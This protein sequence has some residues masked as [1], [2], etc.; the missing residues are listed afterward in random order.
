MCEFREVLLQI[1]AVQDVLRSKRIERIKGIPYNHVSK[2]LQSRIV[3][4]DVHAHLQHPLNM[5][6]ELT[7]TMLTIS[8]VRQAKEKYYFFGND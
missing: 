5:W 1:R 2:M 8:L 4:H 6:P 7:K 3:A